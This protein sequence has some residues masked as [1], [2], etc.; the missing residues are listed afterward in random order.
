MNKLMLMFGAIVF[1]SFMMT[2]CGGATANE[3][4]AEVEVEAPQDD[5]AA[6]VES[7]EPTSTETEAPVSKD[8]KGGEMKPKAGAE[9]K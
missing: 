8:A 3:E 7:T 1:A 9:K 2:S 4:S 6:G 5:T